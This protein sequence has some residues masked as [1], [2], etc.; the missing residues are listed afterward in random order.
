MYIYIYYIFYNFGFWYKYVR[1]TYSIN[2]DDIKKVQNQIKN[3]RL[4]LNVTSFQIKV[5]PS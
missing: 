3:E 4:Q 5:K 1:V 2:D